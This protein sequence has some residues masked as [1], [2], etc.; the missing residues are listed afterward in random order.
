[1]QFEKNSVGTL[2]VIGK[3]SQLQPYLKLKNNSVQ[4]YLQLKKS[5]SCNL[6]CKW[7]K[8]SV[9][10]PLV[11]RNNI[12]VT[13]PLATEK[14]SKYKHLNCNITCNTCKKNH[15]LQLKNISVATLLCNRKTLLRLGSHKN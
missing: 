6:T 4:P 1:M 15:H 14:T 9:A 12:S 3:T 2:L 11:T 7:E 10:T 13:T 8:I 5:L